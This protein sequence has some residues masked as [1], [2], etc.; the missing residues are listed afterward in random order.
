MNSNV[1]KGYTKLREAYERVMRIRMEILAAMHTSITLNTV[2]NDAV[3]K[4]ARE[5]LCSFLKLN[6]NLIEYL[7]HLAYQKAYDEVLFLR[8]S[9]DMFIEHM[10]HRAAREFLTA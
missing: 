4:A 2:V 9:S 1:V 7:S 6:L 8:I 3:V 5:E 10:A